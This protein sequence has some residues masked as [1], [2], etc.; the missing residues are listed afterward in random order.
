MSSEL[1]TAFDVAVIF[2]RPTQTVIGWAKRGWLPGAVW[3]GPHLWFHKSKIDFFVEA[4][5]FHPTAD[6]GKSPRFRITTIGGRGHAAGR[7]RNDRIRKS[8][9]HGLADLVKSDPGVH[10][11]QFDPAIDYSGVEPARLLP[12]AHT[13]SMADVVL[14]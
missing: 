5:G 11:A 4:G 9:D 8:P 7:L 14:A 1:I 12:T 13:P 2:D 3:V 6:V 10:G